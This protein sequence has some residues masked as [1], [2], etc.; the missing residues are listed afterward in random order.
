MDLITSTEIACLPCLP[1]VSDTVSAKINDDT[2]PMVS[3]WPWRSE[4]SSPEG[5]E[6]ALSALAIKV[7]DTQT[8]LDKTRSKSR[9]VRV[10]W[11]LYLGFAYAAYAVAVVLVVGYQRMDLSEWMGMAGGPLM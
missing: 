5:F 4:D 9:R 10:L 7:T 8:H 1:L 6:K 11:S 2:P 3:F